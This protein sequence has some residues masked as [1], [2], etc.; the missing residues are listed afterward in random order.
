[1]KKRTSSIAV[2]LVL[3]FAG[4]AVAQDQ[5]PIADMVANNLILKYQNSTCEQLWQEK[6][7]KQNK[8]KT[9]QQQEMIQI[10]RSSP[11]MRTEFIN[12]IAAPIVNKMFECGM[13]P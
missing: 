2:A 6:M 1:M 10:L 8:P 7:E 12:K 9:P 4:A 13:I 5:F 3:L 11:A